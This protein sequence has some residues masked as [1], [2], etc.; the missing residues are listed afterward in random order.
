M[1]KIIISAS[2]MTHFFSLIFSMSFRQDMF[3]DTVLIYLTVITDLSLLFRSFT[4][5]GI[6]HFVSCNIHILDAVCYSFASF[7]SSHD[8]LLVIILV[9][10]VSSI[11]I[12]I[13]HCSCDGPSR[14]IFGSV[15]EHSS[16]LILS[17]ATFLSSDFVL[18]THT[19]K[20]YRSFTR[21]VLRFASFILLFCDSS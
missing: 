3:P 1:I 4:L 20:L 13:A 10:F 14:C 8:I 6:V 11:T 15:L 18:D 12:D 17:T 2:I 9:I 5:D 21:F 16:F 19:I 7:R